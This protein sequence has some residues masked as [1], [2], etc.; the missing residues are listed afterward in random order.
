[1]KLVR[2]SRIAC[3]STTADVVVPGLTLLADFVTPAEEAALLACIDA[4]PWDDGVV[5]TSTAEPPPTTTTTAKKMA[6][7]VQHY[8]Y[9]FDYATIE[10]DRTPLRSKEPLPPPLA[11]LFDRVRDRVAGLVAEQLTVNE[12]LPGQGIKPH[13][14]SHKSFGAHVVSL[15]LSSPAVFSLRRG[16]TEHKLLLHPRRSLLIL[17][18]P[19]R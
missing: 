12:Y 6:R 14:D 7:R 5:V 1:M 8:G 16:E 13:V 15:G 4:A 2:D 18:G 11:A 19:A 3:T 9:A 17:E 10:I